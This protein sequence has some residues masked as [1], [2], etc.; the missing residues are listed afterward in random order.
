M[1]DDKN[2][3]ATGANPQTDAANAD[4]QLDWNS[5]QEDIKQFETQRNKRGRKSAPSGGGKSAGTK[6]TEPGSFTLPSV[7]VPV[8]IGVIV[9][10]VLALIIFFA[11]QN[12]GGGG[13]N[14]N[15]SI[16]PPSMGG[17]M[18]PH[19]GASGGNA[20][21]TVGKGKTGVT[22]PNQPT[23]QPGITR[24]GAASPMGPGQTGTWTGAG[25]VA[26]QERRRIE[27]Q[28]RNQVGPTR[29]QNS[30]NTTF[31]TRTNQVRPKGRTNEG[32][33]TDP[34]SSVNDY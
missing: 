28:K 8:L 21:P 10:A 1:A 33:G 16:T 14:T 18:S 19:L 24:P 22:S 15:T 30:R 27:Q 11:M 13:A 12:S 32:F 25:T 29:T 9:V 6:N 3:N 20:G 34:E 17:S 2:L 5:I 23:R 26:E 31:S 4:A 7:P